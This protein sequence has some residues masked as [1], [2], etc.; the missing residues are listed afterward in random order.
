M[1]QFII[2]QILTI[3]F[4]DFSPDHDESELALIKLLT[5]DKKHLLW[6]MWE[7]ENTECG[8]KTHLFVE[9]QSDFTLFVLF[10]VHHGP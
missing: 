8:K 3:C 6:N 1:T 4:L 7:M 5:L 9:Q 2:M 10:L